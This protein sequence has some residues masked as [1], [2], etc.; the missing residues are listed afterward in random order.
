[1][2]HTAALLLANLSPLLGR[3]FDAAHIGSVVVGRVG[4]PGCGTMVEGNSWSDSFELQVVCTRC[5]ED[6]MTK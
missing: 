3:N 2:R 6:W 5:F 1:M 4:E